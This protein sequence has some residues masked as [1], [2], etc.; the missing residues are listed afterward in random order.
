MKR[1]PAGGV[2]RCGRRQGAVV[3]TIEQRPSVA[4]P[5]P[6]AI[7]PVP[8]EQDPEKHGGFFPLVWM[9][10]MQFPNFVNTENFYELCNYWKLV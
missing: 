9:D 6:A 3:Y 1:S 2:R 10:L 8:D 7:L 5:P 4:C